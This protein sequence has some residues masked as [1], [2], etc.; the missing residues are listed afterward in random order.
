ML[1]VF[2]LR[3]CQNQRPNANGNDK[4]HIDCMRP[5]FLD[6]DPQISIRFA[7]FIGVRNEF[8][9]NM[10]L[11][12]WVQRLDVIWDF[13]DFCSVMWVKSGTCK[14]NQ[15]KPKI[16]IYKHQDELIHT[17]LNAAQIKPNRLFSHVFTLSWIVGHVCRPCFRHLG[18]WGSVHDIQADRRSAFDGG[19]GGRAGLE[20]RKV[21]VQEVG[22]SEL[23]FLMFL[24]S[25][26]WGTTR[27]IT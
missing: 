9:K 25:S 20:R 27:F 19:F 23:L 6:V 12:M 16:G 3:T 18:P 5:R 7:G 22:Y 10:M 21:A 2:K 11:V 1:T 14:C 17:Q 15:T 4:L 13:R 8:F 24:W 26:F